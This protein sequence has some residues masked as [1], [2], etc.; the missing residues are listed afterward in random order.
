MGP[1]I[2]VG[3][4]GIVATILAPVIT[5]IVKRKSDLKDYPIASH[6]R[7]RALEGKW[8][9]TI[10][11]TTDDHMESVE[12][13]V[14][15]QFHVSGKTITGTADF[16]VENRE[17]KLRLKGLFLSDSVTRLEYSDANQERPRFGAIVAEMDGYGESYAGIIAG[18][19]AWYQKLIHGRIE[20]HKVQ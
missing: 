18:Y 16:V 15:F 13:D 19:S 8:E 17:V 10:K 2:Y 7:R 1:E 20:L 11:Q 12:Y 14:K 3:I 9:G 6:A 4:A 5:L